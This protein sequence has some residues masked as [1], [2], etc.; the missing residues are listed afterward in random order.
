MP[1]IRTMRIQWQMERRQHF[2]Q[3]HLQR[4]GKDK[5]PTEDELHAHMR[6]R[7]RRFWL[8]GAIALLIA[9]YF[10]Q[11]ILL[12][13][14]AM[15]ILSL[16]LVP[17]I[18]QRLVLRDVTFQRTFTDKR[19]RF[20]EATRIRFELENHKLLPVPWLEVEDELSLELEM[21]TAPLFPTYKPDRQ[22]FISAFSLWGHQRVTRTYRLLTRAR[23][24]WT[25]GPTYLRAG[26]PFGFVEREKRLDQRGQPSLIVLPLVAPLTRL[27]LPS[28]NP[29]GDTNAQRRLIEDPSQIIG[30]RDYLPGDPLRRV[31]WKATARTTTMQSKVYPYTTTHTFAIFLDIYTTENPSQGFNTD[32]F[33][34]GIAAAAS[35]SAWASQ[36]RYAVGFFSNGIPASSTDTNF[37]SL[38]A[39]Q[40][41]IR[42][43]P[44]AHPKH[45]TRVLE[46]MARLQ[47][48]FGFGM[49]RLVAREQHTLPIGATVI[50][51][52]SA[53]A[54]QPRT[55]ALLERLKRRGYVVAIL[56]TGDG[57]AS[58]GTL[59]TYRLGGEEAWHALSQE[60]LGERGRGSDLAERPSKDFGTT[61]SGPG[62]GDRVAPPADRHQ[63]AFTVG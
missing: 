40:A 7:P 48:Y 58:T 18:W 42:V 1:D 20:G 61:D 35:I 46:A 31:H 56:L 5:P 14:S 45:L 39:L 10:A 30:A 62:I 63:P 38:E 11:S 54:L 2:E 24:V 34:L 51:I 57:P 44:S 37:T 25:F 22:V 41:S 21:P 28:H 53:R 26:D 43:P 29:F 3:R 8:G 9:S 23:G 6:P 50:V 19:V 60:A 27:G 15:I 13:L 33:E 12:M 4:L 52:T 36:Q 55:V 59:L 32:L 16:G 49:D 17:E 47:P